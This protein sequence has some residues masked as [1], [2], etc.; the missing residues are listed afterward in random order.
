MLTYRFLNIF[1]ELGHTL[2]MLCFDIDSVLSMLVKR[3]LVC[4]VRLDCYT[5]VTQLANLLC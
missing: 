2:P 3:S 5:K 1:D 4:D